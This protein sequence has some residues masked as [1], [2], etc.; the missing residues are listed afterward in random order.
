MKFSDYSFHIWLRNFY[1]HIAA[2]NLDSFLF[3]YIFIDQFQLIYAGIMQA[4][5]LPD[6]I[7]YGIVLLGSSFYVTTNPDERK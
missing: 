5:S 4:F 7:K 6:R 1:H 2:L 3:P